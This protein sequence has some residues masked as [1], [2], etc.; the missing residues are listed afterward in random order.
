MVDLPESI[1]AQI[2]KT[3]DLTLFWNNG[4]KV[5]IAHPPYILIDLPFTEL[6]EHNQIH[7]VNS[8]VNLNEV[9]HLLLNGEP[10][11]S[12]C[13]VG[14]S[15]IPYADRK[16][17][18]RVSIHYCVYRTISFCI[19][20]VEETEIVWTTPSSSNFGKKE[21]YL[22]ARVPDSPEHRRIISE[23]KLVL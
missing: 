18:M 11:L 15:Q 9:N 14:P 5:T 19:L 17:R 13:C 21:R 1:I 20:S 3:A 12:T 23:L 8:S 22:V 10:I 4:Q 6:H 16:S 7:A 2:P